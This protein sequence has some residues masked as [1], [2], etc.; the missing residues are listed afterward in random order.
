LEEFAAG[1]DLAEMAGLGGAFAA[2]PYVTQVEKLVEKNYEMLWP[3]K[4]E[5][6]PENGAPKSRRPA[7]DHYTD[8]CAAPLRK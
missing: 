7:Y 5:Y 8:L 3:K 2:K 4:Q 6:L 1:E